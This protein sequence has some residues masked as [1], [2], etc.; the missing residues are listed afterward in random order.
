MNTQTKQLVS[1]ALDLCVEINNETEL[2]ASL[3]YCGGADLIM[4]EVKSEKAKEEAYVIDKVF[5]NTDAIHYS[6]REENNK[7]K[8]FITLASKLLHDNSPVAY[9]YYLKSKQQANA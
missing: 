3:K 7:L 9:K 5:I 6:E 8:A 1:Q 2:A 4:I